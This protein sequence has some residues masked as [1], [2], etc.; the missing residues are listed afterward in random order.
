MCPRIRYKYCGGVLA[1][2]GN[3]YFVPW[4]ADNVGVFNPA[5]NAFYEVDIS[6]QV[7]VDSKYFGGVLAPNGKIYLT[8]ANANSVGVFDPRS[9]EDPPTYEPPFN[10]AEPCSPGMLH[11]SRWSIVFGNNET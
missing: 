4:W 8:P 10:L 5:T 6:A 1:P 2:N 9:D 7:S 3:I 11:R